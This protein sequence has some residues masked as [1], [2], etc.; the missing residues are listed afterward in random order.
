MTAEEFEE[1]IKLDKERRQTDDSD[2]E[3]E[4]TEEEKELEEKRKR[5]AE[6]VERREHQDYRESAAN[7]FWS[8]N[9]NTI[10]EA[11][12]MFEENH[13]EFLFKIYKALKSG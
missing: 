9:F 7:R 10:E 1:A 11:K 12:A 6:V 13:T 4:L 2:V 3:I 8:E 5:K